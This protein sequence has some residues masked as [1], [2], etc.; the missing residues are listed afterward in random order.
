[1]KSKQIYSA[2][3]L[4]EYKNINFNDNI[5]EIDFF[6]FGLIIFEIDIST[7]KSINNTKILTIN[8]IPSNTILKTNLFFKFL[9]FDNNLEV[10]KLMNKY[11]L[12]FFD[13]LPR[14]KYYLEIINKRI[15]KNFNFNA[16]YQV[17]NDLDRIDKIY[18]KKS[19]N[20]KLNKKEMENLKKSYENEKIKK[21]E[22]F[23]ARIKAIKQNVSSKHKK[24]KTI[25]IFNNSKGFNSFAEKL[26]FVTDL[27]DEILVEKKSLENIYY[28]KQKKENKK[29]KTINKTSSLII[30][31]IENIHFFNDFAVISRLVKKE[32]QIKIV[33]FSHK[34]RNYFKNID[35][36][37]NKIK[38]RK[39]VVKETKKIADDVLINQF[40]K[41]KENLE[42]LIIISNDSDFKNILNE[43][44]KLNIKTT[45]YLTSEPINDNKRW[46]NKAKKVKK[47][48]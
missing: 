31:D 11:G 16:I 23:K 26:G 15:E 42:E 1:M 18:K 28:K 45:I 14:G 44:N 21:Q 24:A 3:I 40:H 7:N 8:N 37:L 36:E 39:W 33:S 35:F 2:I 41:Y 17:Y 5:I 46:Y 13:K 34:F 48:N 6:D 43:A 20:K 32:N 29:T 47:I 4:N 38:K 10:Y 25:D 30:W 27:E 22:E 12:D 9:G 19:N